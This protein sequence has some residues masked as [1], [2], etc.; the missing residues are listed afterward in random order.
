M[1]GSINFSNKATK[2][3]QNDDLRII[4]LEICCTISDKIYS[5][6]T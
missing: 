5:I 6:K 4:L 2:V 3:R 1:F